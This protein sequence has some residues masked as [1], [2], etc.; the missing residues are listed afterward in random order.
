MQT[1]P[2]PKTVDEYMALFPQNVRDLLGTF[3]IVVLE[4]APEAQEYIGYE[5]PAYKLYGRVL[6]YFAGFSKHVSLFPG[7]QAILA[8][9]EEL[10]GY[11]T[12]G[13]T[14]RFPLDKT[15]PVDLVKRIIE[16]RMK[17]N[18]EKTKKKS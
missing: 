11:K 9:K 1:T 10:T 8:F 12:S 16:F 4:T 18:S 13:G 15:L 7:P 5:M 3:R 2:K 14:I 6:I 17:E